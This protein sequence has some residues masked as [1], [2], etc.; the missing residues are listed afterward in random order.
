MNSKLATTFERDRYS[1]FRP[2]LLPDDL[3][4]IYRY[5]KYVR[6]AWRHVAR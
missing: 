1:V 5:A 4:R 3:L 2:A 6:R